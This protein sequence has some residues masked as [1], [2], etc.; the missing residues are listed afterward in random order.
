MSKLAPIAAVLLA[1]VPA[2]LLRSA[3]WA[4]PVEVSTALFGLA[5]VAA[6]FGLSWAAEAAERDVPRALALTAVALLA[7]LPEYSVD[8]VFA[9]KAGRDPSFAPYAAANMTGSNRL[10]LGIGWPAVVGFA[11]LRHRKAIVHLDRGSIPGLAFLG[12]ATV[13]SFILPLGG[14]ISLLDSAVL[15]ALFFAYAALSARAEKAEPDL[16]GPAATIGALPALPRRLAIAGLM[17]FAFLA[18][19]A[20]AGPFAE[21]LIHTGRAL[22]VDEFLLVQWLAPFASEAP[23]FLVA[24]LL[25]SRGKGTAALG[26]LVS[27]KLNQWTLL[28]GSLPVAYSFGAGQAGA[29]VLDQRQTAEV[30]LTAAQSLFGLSVIA[31]LSLSL[32]RGGLLAGLFLLQIA[33]GGWLRVGLHAPDAASDELL[34]FTILYLML[35]PLFF[36]RARET[37]LRTR[38][39]SVRGDAG[40]MIREECSG[41]T[42]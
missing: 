35:A 13:Y 20:S 33:L 34:G 8:I 26:L 15:F 11:W 23:E 37:L 19:A 21:G 30:L 22:R 27:A 4:A 29:L 5:I 6:A 12:T 16:V 3:L 25:A 10:L 40:A 28:V 42:S 18:I 38:L 32:W 36:F 17:A 1:V 41:R 31:T 39:V 2:L 7:V 14:T 9:W 24:G